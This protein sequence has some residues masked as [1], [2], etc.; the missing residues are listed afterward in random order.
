MAAG[1]FAGEATL[2]A[3][4]VGVE[5]EV[6]AAGHAGASSSDFAW[7]SQA[8]DSSVGTDSWPLLSAWVPLRGACE[9]PRA[10]RP[11]R[12]MPRP[13]PRVPSMRPPLGGLL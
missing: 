10:L 8:D 13:R 7:L 4:G 5:S 1:G 11:P 2:A 9:R 3:A 6:A 12:S